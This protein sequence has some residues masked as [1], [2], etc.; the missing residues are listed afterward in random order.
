M[1]HYFR[2][3]I[4]LYLHPFTPILEPCQSPQDYKLLLTTSKFLLAID[5]FMLYLLVTFT[6][7]LEHMP[8]FTSNIIDPNPEFFRTEQ[9]HTLH[10]QLTH[11]NFANFGL[12]TL[13]KLV[14]LQYK[15]LLYHEY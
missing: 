7:M 14:L 9:I 8:N 15:N 13:S 6:S 5:Y 10:T 3:Y 1:Y 2:D 4:S 11:E 12:I